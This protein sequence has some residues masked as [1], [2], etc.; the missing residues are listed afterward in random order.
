MILF[1]INYCKEILLV[2]LSFA[3]TFLLIL[4]MIVS[5]NLASNHLNIV[6]LSLT[7]YLCSKSVITSVP[8]VILTSANLPI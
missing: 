8:S 1:F 6:D 4:A 3:A 2:M 7:S 5:A